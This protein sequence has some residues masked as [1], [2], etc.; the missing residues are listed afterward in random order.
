MSEEIV[1][2]VMTPRRPMTLS[3][4]TGIMNHRWLA[5]F[6]S[7][8]QRF[9]LPSTKDGDHVTC[10]HTPEVSPGRSIDSHGRRLRGPC[11]ARKRGTAGGR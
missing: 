2:H 11:G 7:G 4:S 8:K 5:P 10:N 9:S 6:R 3:D 1:G